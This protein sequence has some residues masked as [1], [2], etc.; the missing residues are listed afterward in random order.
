MLR[1]FAV[2]ISFVLCTNA[3]GKEQDTSRLVI[4]QRVVKEISANQKH[5]Y[6]LNVGAKQFVCGEVSQKNINIAVLMIDPEGN[7]IGRSDMLMGQ[8]GFYLETTSGGLYR[9]EIIPLRFTNS[10]TGPGEYTIEIKCAETLGNSPDKQIDQIID[11]LYSDEG[12]GGSVAVVRDGRIIYS[13]A[14]GMANMSHMVPYTTETSTN[15][16]SVS[17]Q[18]TGFAIALLEKEGKLSLDDDIREFIPE[19]PDFGQ[20]VT[21]KNLLNHTGGYRE[22]NLTYGMRGGRGGGSTTREHLIKQIQ[23][24]RELQYAPG[25]KHSYCNT[26]YILM[27][28]VVER[29]SGMAFDQWMEANVFGPL[30]M[31][32]T[33]VNYPIRGQIQKVVPNSAQ[34]TMDNYGEYGTAP[35]EP[36]FY[37]ASSIYS[38]AG[39]MSKWLINLNDARVGGQEVI[40]RLTEPGHTDRR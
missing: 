15:I 27:A 26:G 21:L 31:K 32:H 38:T 9:I 22:I 5:I 3:S 10:V 7:Q 28:E 16:G 25:S 33:M 17:K 19:C 36:A 24:Q 18:F 14:Y 6:L 37:G 13:R 1:I 39:D 34:G 35:D 30:G 29:V 8:K 2:F 40:S 11:A 20:P 12:P 23:K 4:G